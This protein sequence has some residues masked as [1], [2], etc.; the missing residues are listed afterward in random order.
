[1]S[2]CD[3]CVKHLRKFTNELKVYNRA[4]LARHRRQGD[5]DD[6]AYKGHPLCE[7]CDERFLDNDELHTHLRRLHFWC[8]FCEREGGQQYY[9][10]YKHLRQHFRQAHFLCEEGDCLHEQYTSVFS[11][12]V[13]FQAHVAVKHAKKLSKAEARQARQLDVDLQLPPRGRV[14]PFRRSQGPR[15]GADHWPKEQQAKEREKRAKFRFV[16]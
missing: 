2:Y 6:S 5:A 16:V 13:D 11:T 9:P 15:E 10:D 7:F 1:M 3:L 4:D 14:G 8:H 12:K